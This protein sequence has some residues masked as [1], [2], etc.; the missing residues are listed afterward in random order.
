MVVLTNDVNFVTVKPATKSRKAKIQPNPKGSKSICHLPDF[1]QTLISGTHLA[2]HDLA[3]C[4]YIVFRTPLDL[5]TMRIPLTHACLSFCL[6][7]LAT[8]TM[9]TGIVASSNTVS[10][11]SAPASVQSDQLT[12]NNTIF[13]FK[14][15]T[16]ALPTALEVNGTAPGEYPS[17]D[18]YDIGFNYTCSSRYIAAG[19]LVSSYL[20]HTDLDAIPYPTE[21]LPFRGTATFDTEI[22]GLI[23]TSRLLHDSDLIVGSSNTLYPASDGDGPNRQFEYEGNSF[24]C[25]VGL[26][27]CV[28]L[29][30]DRRTIT[31]AFG[32]A[33]YS[34]ELRV[35]VAVPAPVT[36]GLMFAALPGWIVVR[37]RR[38]NALPMKRLK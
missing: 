33:W 29:S 35:I 24:P 13:V 8:Q 21:P 18:C 19:T 14:E 20:F 10:L 31:L 7:V 26:A 23:F 15:S 12:S 38:G 27:D 25:P 9:A 30:A 2:F 4:F 17:P 22:L 1:L 34:D 16:I 32:T 28:S 36:L 5:P 3:P 6:A 37:A 11:I